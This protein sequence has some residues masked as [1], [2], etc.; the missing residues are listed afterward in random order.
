MVQKFKEL[1]RVYFR[2][3]K[4]RFIVTVS[5][6]VIWTGLSLY[7]SG[8]VDGEVNKDVYD[9]NGQKIERELHYSG[10]D[11]R[12]YLYRVHNR[13]PSWTPF[14]DERYGLIDLDSGE[15][16]EPRFVESLF[17]GNDGYAWD[18]EGHYIDT[19]GN[20]VITNKYYMENDMYLSNPLKFSIYAFDK[21]IANDICLSMNY[22]KITYLRNSDNDYFKY[23]LGYD[24][25]DFSNGYAIYYTWVRDNYGNYW[26]RCGYL[27]MNGD[28]VIKPYFWSGTQFDKNGYAIVNVPDDEEL[29]ASDL[30]AVIDSKYDSTHEYVIEPEYRD[31]IIDKYGLCLGDFRG[32]CRTADGYC[33]EDRNRY[34]LIMDNDG[35]FYE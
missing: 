34:I 29:Y 7:L 11:N 10:A 31:R 24:R 20:I 5:A 6:L 3:H 27:D 13:W 18:Y 4:V 16:T 25:G 21:S 19:K 8:Y 23:Y 28:M 22:T 14:Y 33:Y 9:G 1:I 2:E 15:C 32:F 26:K 35:N 30:F 12:I 17:F